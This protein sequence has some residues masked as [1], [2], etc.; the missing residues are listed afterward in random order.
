MKQQ[1]Q[2]SGRFI[3]DKAGNY[4]GEIVDCKCNV[5][6]CQ[7]GGTSVFA[8][9]YNVTYCVTRFFPGSLYSAFTF[10]GIIHC[11]SYP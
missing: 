8:I 4:F 1:N 2:P 7:K 3:H 5:C 10:R 6:K 9:L 11:Y